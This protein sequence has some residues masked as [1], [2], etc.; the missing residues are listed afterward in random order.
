MG[1]LSRH[2]P[3]SGSHP[4]RV[5]CVPDFAAYKSN[6]IN[7]LPGRWIPLV[8][9]S[10]GR[11]RQSLQ[12]ILLGFC[13]PAPHPTPRGHGRPIKQ[14]SPTSSPLLLTQVSPVQHVKHSPGSPDDDMGGLHLELLDLGPDIRAPYAGM[15]GC[16]HVVPQGHHHFLDLWGKE[17]SKQSPGRGRAQAHPP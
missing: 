7:R 13:I 3:G 17:R 16:A 2:K 11:K 5:A 10:L 8:R 9:L 12:G 6:E 14:L 15:A 1:W 4:P